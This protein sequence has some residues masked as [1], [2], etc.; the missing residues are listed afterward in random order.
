MTAKRVGLLVPA[1]VTGDLT[2]TRVGH[3]EANDSFDYRAAE[4]SPERCASVNSQN[5]WRVSMNY[6]C[7][8][9]DSW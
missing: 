1:E 5:L 4:E 8:S 2:L 3:L 7:F 6:C 9:H